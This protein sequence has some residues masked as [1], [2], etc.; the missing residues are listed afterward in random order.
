MFIRY[1][2]G[3]PWVVDVVSAYVKY[4]TNRINVYDETRLALNIL[5]LLQG[6]LI[7]VTLVCKL[8]VYTAIKNKIQE[9]KYSPTEA[10]D[11][12]EI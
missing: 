3:I 4:K 1:I 9:M 10:S 6:L 5:N 11:N 12:I 8:S 7:F 2:A